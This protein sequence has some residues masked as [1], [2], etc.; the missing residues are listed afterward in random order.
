MGELLFTE[1][2]KKDWIKLLNENYKQSGTL[3][4]TLESLKALKMTEI[5][6]VLVICQFIFAIQ[7]GH[8]AV[9]FSFA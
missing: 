4:H 8:V 2:W 9:S 3:I 1:I 7:V 6:P 5:S